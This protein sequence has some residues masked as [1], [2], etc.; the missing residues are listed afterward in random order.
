MLYCINPV[1]CPNDSQCLEVLLFQDLNDLGWKIY[2]THDSFIIEYLGNAYF[3]EKYFSCYLKS[4]VN[5]TF[6][7]TNCILFKCTRVEVFLNI[8]DAITN[9]YTDD[10]WEFLQNLFTER[11]DLDPTLMSTEYM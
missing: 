3:S 11:L 5:I 7:N 10:I 2:R 9:N 8:R 6:I 1:E 4:G